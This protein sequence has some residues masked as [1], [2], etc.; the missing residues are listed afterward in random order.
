MAI[1]KKKAEEEKAYN[2]Q[3]ERNRIAS[4]KQMAETKR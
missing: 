2:E 3:A 4:T 1:R